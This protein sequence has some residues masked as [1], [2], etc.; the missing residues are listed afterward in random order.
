MRTRKFRRQKAKKEWKET[1]KKNKMSFTEFWR[2]KYI[3]S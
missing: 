1:K 3:K 2:K